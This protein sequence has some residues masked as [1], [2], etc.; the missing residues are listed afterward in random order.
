MPLEPMPEPVQQLTQSSD[1]ELQQSRN[2]WIEKR[3][4]WIEAMLSRDTSRNSAR[5]YDS[6]ERD[7]PTHDTNI[8]NH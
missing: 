5:S 1:A 6:S 3:S 8:E 2:V 4:E 7:T